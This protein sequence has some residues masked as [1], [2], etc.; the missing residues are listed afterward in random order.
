MPRQWPESPTLDRANPWE[1]LFSGA[2][3]IPPWAASVNLGM[4]SGT[5]FGIFVRFQS[6]L[7]AGVRTFRLVTGTTLLT[8]TDVWGAIWDP[9]TR[10]RVAD[11]GNIAATTVAASTVYDVP[12]TVPDLFGNYVLGV[13]FVGTSWTVFGAN[14]GGSTLLTAIAERETFSRGNSGG[15]V[16]GGPVPAL[17]TT[18]TSNAFS[19]KVPYLA[20]F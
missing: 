20:V 4:T 17:T 18:G 7:R 9:V 19:S 3:T 15:L 2:E 5:M 14:A 1:D 13:G 12:I 8:G 10:Q 16:A 11:T 6:I